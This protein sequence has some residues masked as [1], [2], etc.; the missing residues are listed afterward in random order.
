M[1]LFL[2]GFVS[3]L[4]LAV[5]EIVLGVDNIVFVGILSDRLPP[6]KRPLARRLGLLMALITRIIFLTFVSYLAGIVTPLFV[7][8]GHGVTVKDLVLLL[9]GLFLLWKATSELHKQVEGESESHGADSKVKATLWGVVGSIMLMDVIF[10][11]DS[12]ITAVGMVNN[13]PIMIAAVVVAMMVMIASVNKISDFISAHPT[14]R[15]LALAFLLLIGFTLVVGATGVEVAKGYIYFAMGFSVFVE[16][17]N[18]RM[19]KKMSV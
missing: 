2:T 18:M 10:S 17:V 7:V 6:E 5:L 8:L 1:D 16:M 9:G 11:L 12:V 14:I 13:I 19:R 15:V 4:T 3:F